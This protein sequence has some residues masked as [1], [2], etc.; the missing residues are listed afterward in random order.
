VGRLGEGDE[1]L[2]VER[3][4]EGGGEGDEEGDLCGGFYGQGL[5]R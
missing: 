5:I 1:E 4:E 3:A 2:G